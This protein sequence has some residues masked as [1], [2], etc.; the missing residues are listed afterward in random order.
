MKTSKRKSHRNTT[1]KVRNL[2]IHGKI[3]SRKNGWI[4]MSIYGEPYE[5]GY[6]HGSLLASHFSH[7]D[8]VFK[9]IVVSHFHTT[10]EEYLEICTRLISPVVMND[11]SEFYEEIRGINEGIVSAGVQNIT[12]HYLIAW[13]ALLSM[14]S[15]YSN[16]H[17]QRC[18]AFIATGEATIDGK[19]VMA[20]NTHSDFASGVLGNIIL[21]VHPAMGHSFRMQTYPGYIASGTDWFLCS[22]GIIGCETTISKTNYKPRFGAPYFCRI[23]QAMQYANTLDECAII[24]K[25]DNAGDYACSWLFGDINENTIMLC[26]IGRN[27]THVEKTNTGVFYGAN[28]AIDY[29]LRNTETTDS[30]DDLTTSTGARTMRLQSMLLREYYGKL[31]TS[32]AKNILSDHYDVYINRI[33]PGQRTICKHSKSS[34]W[35]ATDGKV[36]DATMAKNLTFYGRMGPPCGGNFNAKQFIQRHPKY[37]EWDTVFQDIPKR[38]WTKI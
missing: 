27:K 1:I 14:Y 35:G 29:E 24:M 28:T 31:T 25:K 3:N 17:G 34:P 7:V 4:I 11:Y 32:N 36:V 18:C 12:V 19:I 5:R 9:Y 26:E 16:N 6:A 15:H 22:S 23:R 10:F 8:K 20:H 30:F 13:N 37:K 38:K 33:D 21:H 2:G